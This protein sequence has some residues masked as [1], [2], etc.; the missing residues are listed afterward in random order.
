MI[1]SKLGGES[2][3]L[4]PKIFSAVADALLWILV[5]KGINSLLHYLDDFI[6]VSKS[7]D[8]AKRK[9][10]TLVSTFTSLGVPLE[11]SKLTA[12]CLTFL[13]IELDTA[14]LHLRLPNDKLQCLKEALSRIYKVSPAFAARCQSG[15]AGETLLT[16]TICYSA[17]GDPAFPSH[18][19][20]TRGGIIWWHIFVDKWNG[21]ISLRFRISFPGDNSLLRCFRVFG[22]RELRRE[23][24]VRWLVHHQGLSI[25]SKELIPVVIS[26]AIF[27]RH[28]SGK[29]VNFMVDNLA[30]VHVLQKHIAGYPPYAPYQIIG[31]ACSPLQLLVYH[32]PCCRKEKY[33]C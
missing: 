28:W 3:P 5:Q 4:A 19:A 32:R 29:L 10:C 7:P 22:L 17:G 20:A 14:T 21:I 24:L 6:F 30:V 16:Q 8:E 13:G 26:A 27:R 18:S 1:I 9:M 25:V 15:K 23:R 2:I 11:P 33:F 31:T 12:N